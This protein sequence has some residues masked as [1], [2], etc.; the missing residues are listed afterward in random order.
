MGRRKVY[1]GE[2]GSDLRLVQPILTALQTSS[3]VVA[4]SL[5]FAACGPEVTRDIVIPETERRPSIVGVIDRVEFVKGTDRILVLADGTRLRRDSNE[6]QGSAPME[7]QLLLYGEDE[8]GAFWLGLPGARD[9]YQ[10]SGEA[11]IRGSRMVFSF[12]LS[13]PLAVEF[14]RGSQRDGRFVGP[15]LYRFCINEQGEV[16]SVSF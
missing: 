8:Q 4:V 10:L 13:L 16:V 3:V 12:G 11:E 15:W 1:T 14:S 6:V 9:C 5:M 7:G 2:T